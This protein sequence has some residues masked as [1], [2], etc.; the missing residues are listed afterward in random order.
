MADFT[1]LKVQSGVGDYHFN[2]FRVAFRK[3]PGISKNFLRR[4]SLRTSPFI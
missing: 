4:I 3:P 1:E 2:R